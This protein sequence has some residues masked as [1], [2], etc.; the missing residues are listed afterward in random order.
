MAGA[1]LLGDWSGLNRASIHDKLAARRG[2]PEALLALSVLSVSP[3]W[4]KYLT[5]AVERGGGELRLVLSIIAAIVPSILFVMASIHR[6]RPPGYNGR[7]VKWL[8]KDRPEKDYFRLLI[9]IFGIQLLLTFF[10]W[11]DV[12]SIEM[13]GTLLRFY[14][15]LIPLN[16]GIVLGFTILFAIAGPRTKMHLLRIG[17]SALLLF[18]SILAMGE[19]GLTI[20]T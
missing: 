5:S 10:G 12:H 11:L 14:L 20:A 18:F 4:S 15:I 8:E 17:L 2:L 3:P 6:H 19:V 7:L 13:T 1:A 16:S 9:L